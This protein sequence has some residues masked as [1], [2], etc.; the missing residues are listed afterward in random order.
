MREATV[1][2]S[3]ADKPIVFVHI[4]RC[5]GTSVAKAIR[6]A[7]NIADAGR[8][9]PI[10]AR[11]AAE[12]LLEP[13]DAEEFFAIYP[14]LQQYLLSYMLR[15][16]H[17]LISG[18]L[19]VGPRILNEFSDSHSFLSILRDPVERWISHYVYNALTNLDPLV[20]PTRS[21]V[22]DIL[23]DLN[24]ILENKRGWQLG[25]LITTFFSGRPVPQHD[26]RNIVAIAN[27][28][29]TKFK[30]IGFLHDLNAFSLKYRDLYGIELSI[31]SLNSIESVTEEFVLLEELQGMFTNRVRRKIMSLCEDDYRVYERALNLFS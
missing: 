5:A 12:L 10:R 30:L 14:L 4:P 31:P 17:T 18:H 9:D 11:K 22:N 7:S 19:P 25:H 3:L 28:N 2:E 1:N 13:N 8:I 27:L 29:L 16:D 6:S 21:P 15:D 23:S 20:A 24:S 26:S